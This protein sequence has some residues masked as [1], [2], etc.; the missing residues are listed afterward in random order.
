MSF[1]ICN[2]EE[3]QD[4]VNFTTY[5][6]NEVKVPPNAKIGVYTC[7]INITPE[8]EITQFNNNLAVMYDYQYQGQ[9]EGSAYPNLDVKRYLPNDIFLTPGIYSVDA[10]ANQIY[11]Q[12]TWGDKTGLNQYEVE[13]LRDGSTNQKYQGFKISINPLKQITDAVVKTDMTNMVVHKLDTSGHDQTIGKTAGDITITKSNGGSNFTWDSLYILGGALTRDKSVIT[14]EPENYANEHFFGLT[15]N[16]YYDNGSAIENFIGGIN[17]ELNDGR[18]LGLTPVGSFCDYAVYIEN[19]EVHLYY[20]KQEAGLSEMVEVEYWNTGF[21]TPEIT[22]IITLTA[23]NPEI[24]FHIDNEIVI[25]EVNDNGAGFVQINRGTEWKGITS[26]TMVLYPLVGLYVDNDSNKV[27][28]SQGAGS[29]VCFLAPPGDVNSVS[30]AMVNMPHQPIKNEF[31]SNNY[32][33]LID[34]GWDFCVVKNENGD[35]LLNS[36]AV[37]VVERNSQIALEARE[38]KADDTNWNDANGYLGTFT[39]GA[40]SAGVDAYSSEKSFYPYLLTN[41]VIE[42]PS[43]PVYITWETGSNL[44]N[45]LQIEN[46]ILKYQWAGTPPAVSVASDDTPQNI[47]SSNAYVRINNLPI[48]TYNG[49][50]NSLSRIIGIVPRFNSHRSIGNIY[51]IHNPPV[52]IKLNNV[53]ELVLSKLSLSLVDADEKLCK[54]IS[55]NTQIM[56]HLIE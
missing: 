36:Q 46:M 41:R 30:Q 29:G 22:D 8:I 28:S 11:Y 31:I 6:R 40:F 27:S 55:G 44:G 54:D 18:E 43:S 32:I 39:A 17:A 47:N 37:K 50:S 23:D 12:L 15:R 25:V 19:A 51:T 42:Q 24:R 21:G 20:C 13:V 3:E 9:V 4:A 34:L 52:Y 48:Q 2:S 14:F 16:I 35:A 38:R 56:F 53:D 5:F 1:I 49:T 26:A 33:K 45:L 10:L 7:Q